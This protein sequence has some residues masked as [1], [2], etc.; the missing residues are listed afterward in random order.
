MVGNSHD[1]WSEAYNKATYGGV[2]WMMEK[3]HIFDTM[4][5]RGCSTGAYKRLNTDHDYAE[6][7]PGGS[8]DAG[9]S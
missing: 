2:V 6:S 8:G 5:L 9:L 7:A 4:C 1:D 3:E